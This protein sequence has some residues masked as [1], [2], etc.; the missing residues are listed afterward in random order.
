MRKY[1]TYFSCGFFPHSLNFE[2]CGLKVKPNVVNSFYS[3]LTSFL[4][5]GYPTRPTHYLEGKIEDLIPNFSWEGNV[6]PT[7]MMVRPF[8]PNWDDTIKGFEED[9]LF[10]A[11]QFFNYLIEE[12]LPDYSFIKNLIVPECKFRDILASPF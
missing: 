8:K 1:N 12:H 6:E 4:E 3:S 11:R 2:A 5:R 7:H 9:G 10:P